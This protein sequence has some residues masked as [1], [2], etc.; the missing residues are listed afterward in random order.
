MKQIEIKDKQLTIYTQPISMIIK[1]ILGFL[2]LAIAGL[3]TADLFG[4]LNGGG[5]HFSYLIG[6]VILGL[7]GWYFLR[8]LLWNKNGKEIITI[9]NHTLS[10]TA[11][12]GLFK[13][14]TKT[15]QL[16]N[17][18]KVVINDHDSRPNKY[19]SFENLGDS[20]GKDNIIA[21][22]IKLKYSSDTDFNKLE[23]DLNVWL[24]SNK[25]IEVEKVDHASSAE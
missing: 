25:A 17:E 1:V 20:S 7:I 2:L 4:I 14:G 21:S 9:H 12:Y 19:I 5:F 23:Q 18:T 8:I 3:I 10:Y 16:S 15:F 11:N 22:V 6:L 13:D 24:R